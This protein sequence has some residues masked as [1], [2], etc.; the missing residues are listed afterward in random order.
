M[1][2]DGAREGRRAFFSE[3]TRGMAPGSVDPNAEGSG[4]VDRHSLIRDE[5]GAFDLTVH[6]GSCHVI[7]VVNLGD[8]GLRTFPIPIVLPWQSHPLRAKCPACGRRSW[9]SVRR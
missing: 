1:N 8:L 4:H 5:K 7:S 3:E 2:S 9:L 6:C